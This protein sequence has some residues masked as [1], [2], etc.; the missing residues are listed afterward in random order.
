M[1]KLFSLIITLCF[2]QGVS[3]QEAV[4]LGLSVDWAAY[5][6]GANNPEECGLFF[7]G[8]TKDIYNP[9][10]KIKHLVLPKHTADYSG[11]PDYDAATAYWGDGWRTPT[12]AEWSE[13]IASCNW[14]WYEYESDGNLICGYQVIGPNGNSIKLPAYIKGFLSSGHGAGYQCSTPF[15]NSKYLYGFAYFKEKKGINKYKHMIKHDIL[16]TLP[17][18]AVRDK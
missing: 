15:H 17:T 18:R 10:I 5:N 14:V 2:M 16:H 9:Q 13:L 1:K 8:G 12:Y 11:N 4:D 6:I 3:A 7:I